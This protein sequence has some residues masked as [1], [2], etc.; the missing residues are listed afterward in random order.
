MCLA[1][2]GYN[3]QGAATGMLFLLEFLVQELIGL[4][5]WP[6]MISRGKVD[7]TVQA[8]SPIWSINDRGD[9][10]GIVLETLRAL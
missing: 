6:V 8:P 3:I 10:L 1:C 5:M 9:D 7:E 2:I 4:L